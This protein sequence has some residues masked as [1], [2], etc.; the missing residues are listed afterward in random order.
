MIQNFTD[1]VS[2]KQMSD[3]GP[4]DKVSS[5]LTLSA[6]TVQTK[7]Q[8]IRSSQLVKSPSGS[9]AGVRLRETPMLGIGELIIENN[10]FERGSE[11]SNNDD[12]SSYM[13]DEEIQSPSQVEEKLNSESIEEKGEIDPEIGI[14]LFINE[15]NGDRNDFFQM[16]MSL[17]RNEQQV[18]G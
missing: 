17:M 1:I 2:N 14:E 6:N 12:S 10:S 15:E 18:S 9:C 7:P 8:A 11:R 5:K 16:Q 4:F 3:D 13:D